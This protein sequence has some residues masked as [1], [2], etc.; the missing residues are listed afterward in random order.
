MRLTSSTLVL[1]LT[2]SVAVVNG[3]KLY[4]EAQHQ[5]GAVAARIEQQLAQR[6]MLH[7]MAEHYP[8]Q[9]TPSPAPAPSSSSGAPGAVPSSGGPPPANAQPSVSY[10]YSLA[11]VNP[12]AVPLSNI[13]SLAPSSITGNLPSTPAAGETPSNVLSA[14]GL[15]APTLL[16]AN[17]PPLDQIP[18]TNSPE[19]QQWIKEVK[20][21]GVQIPDYPQN[22]AGGCPANLAAA[23]NK[24]QCWWTCS[25]CTRPT[26][27]S[28]CPEKNTWGLTYDDGPAP[29]TPDLLKYLD[30]VDIKSTFFVVGSRVLSFPHM[31]QYEYMA[32]HQISIHTWSHKQLTTLT[33]DQIIA[34]L[35]WT[36]KIIKDVLGVTPNSMRPPFGDID[37]RVRAICKAMNL[38]PILWTRLSPTQTLDTGD[39]DIH[40]G[41]ATVDEVLYNW[42]NILGNVTSIDHGFIV[43]EHDLFQQ[44]VEVA[45]GYILPDAIARGDFKIMPVT[46][47]LNK[48]MWDSY[49]ETNDNTTNPPALSHDSVVT[50]TSGAPGSA[51]ATGALAGKNAAASSSQV[52]K[53]VLG[54]MMVGVAGLVVL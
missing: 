22:V 5:H 16:I 24:E 6:G 44:S 3:H 54:L 53:S 33:N 15:P 32:G 30:E 23:Q 27:I 46:T 37:D 38:T 28:D 31:L 40:G 45:T 29:Y 1:A 52:A 12:T 9:N 14:P 47:C 41:L 17:Y 51:Q 18:D 43:L 48:P 35:G 7:P 8:R 34:E 50:L 36:K 26:D 42:Q 49:I 4:R 13:N 11:S 39:F 10:S 21:S 20:E 19:V 25:G 2:S